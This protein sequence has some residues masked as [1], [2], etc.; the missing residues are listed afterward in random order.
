MGASDLLAPEARSRGSAQAL[1]D[2]ID[3]YTNWMLGTFGHGPFT[4]N[5]LAWLHAWLVE[6]EEDRALGATPQ[7]FSGRIDYR[8]GSWA[9]R[10]AANQLPH[11]REQEAGLRGR[12]LNRVRIYK[13]DRGVV[14]SIMNFAARW[15]TRPQAI[16]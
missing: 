1:G 2:V 11:V 8:E 7:T 9:S 3:L 12:L 5:L 14:S 10:E 15:L 6:L 13:P 16:H 4:P